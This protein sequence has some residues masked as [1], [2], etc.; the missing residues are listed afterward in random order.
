MTCARGI[1]GKTMSINV[2]PFIIIG[3]LATLI[4]ADHY[5]WTDVHDNFE[6]LFEEDA[7]NYEQKQNE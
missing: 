2:V 4:R 1:G 5:G 7:T 3:V 6:K